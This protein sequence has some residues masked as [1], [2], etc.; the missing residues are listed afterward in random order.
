MGFE[1]VGIYSIGYNLATY[2]QG[3]F[4]NTIEAAL[5]PMT[6]N[7]WNK[8]GEAATQKF[9]TQYFSIYSLIFFPVIFGLTAVAHDA[10][11][12]IGSEKFAASAGIVGYIIIG[13]MT[14]GAL[15][16]A[17]AGLYFQ[18][19]TTSIAKSTFYAASLNMILNI[20]WVPFWGIEGAAFATLISCVFQV[21]YSYWKSSKF[22]KIKHNFRFYGLCLIS[23]GVMF[24]ALKIFPFGGRTLLLNF[25]LKIIVGTSIYASLILTFDRTV[26]NYLKH[27]CKQ[28]SQKIFLPV[29]N[30]S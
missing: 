2:V 12:I 1:A 27:G 14:V 26:R 25:V 16:P 22:I 9:L 20:F 6:M 23:A 30:N 24:I 21:G 29:E 10:V 17:S 19:K 15:F 7:I 4:I 5:I 13:V 28:L 3:L 11:I 18:K 8:Q